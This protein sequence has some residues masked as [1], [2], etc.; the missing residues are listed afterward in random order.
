M[1]SVHI[2]ETRTGT[3]VLN[4]LPVEGEIEFNRQLNDDGRIQI[5]VPIGDR[6]TPTADRMRAFVGGWRYSLAVSAGPARPGTPV[7]AYGPIMAHKF[8][9]ASSTLTIGA[10]S[11]WA[12]LAR[13]LVI[14]PA[15]P[16]T[17]PLSMEATMDAEYLGMTLWGIARN[18]VA[19]TLARGTGFELP[20]DLPDS[21]SGDHERLYPIYDLATVGQRLKDLTQVEHGPDVD[22][23]TRFA[24]NS[25]V[26][27]TMR[28]GTP[29]LTQFGTDL[30]WDD[31]SSLTYIDADSSAQN[32]STSNYSRG[33]ATERASQVAYANDSTLV[34]AGWPVL[35]SVDTSHQSVV[36]FD[37]LQSH[38]N[39]WVRFYKN[40]VETWD[41]ETKTNTSPVV[42]TYKP[43]DTARFNIQKHPW[44]PRGVY[45]QRILGWSNAGSERLK[46]I[47]EAS[48]GAA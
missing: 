38:A 26:R 41:A 3:V 40:P 22:W 48:E 31:T 43:G 1:F 7:L 15:A 2:V 30:I 21:T 39:E 5:Q 32:M 18:L 45:H 27:T 9:H 13:R 17:S 16:I 34:N 12:L 14:D 25:T 42:G 11:M 23:E 36:D 35:E 8:N 29:A 46:L 20:I 47:L 6:G 10:G 28:V 33:N 4:E 37:T 19:D 24:T 44:I